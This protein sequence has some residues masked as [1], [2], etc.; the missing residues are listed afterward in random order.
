[1]ETFL[2]RGY[3]YYQEKSAKEQHEKLRKALAGKGDIP[4]PMYERGD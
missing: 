4:V 3:T 2:Y 1:M